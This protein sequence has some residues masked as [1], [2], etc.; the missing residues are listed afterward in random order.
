MG[1]VYAAYDPDGA[2]ANAD[3][4]FGPTFRS[5]RGGSFTDF[6]ENSFAT[7]FRYR[8]KPAFRSFNIG[9]R[10]IRDAD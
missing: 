8:Q 4:D 7:T 2:Y 5:L 6:F 9:F 10:C 1:G 3:T